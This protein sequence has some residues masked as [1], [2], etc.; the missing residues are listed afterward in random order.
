MER[1]RQSLFQMMTSGT[2]MVVWATLVA[3]P[4][5]CSSS[6]GG[7]DGVD[8]GSSS[9]GP[10][11]TDPG[12]QGANGGSG[13]QRFDSLDATDCSSNGPFH[14]QACPCG[15]GETSSCWTGPAASRG[16]GRCHD[17]TQTCMASG[18]LPTWG[19]CEGEEKNCDVVDAGVCE[20]VPGAEITCDED[21]AVNLYCVSDGRKTCLPDRTWSPCRED[22]DAAPPDIAGAISGALGILGSVFGDGGS[23]GGGPCR[24]TGFG[25]AAVGGFSL[26]GGTMSATNPANQG[27]YSG[28][29]SA[30]FA[31]GH[32]P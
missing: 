6:R 23:V 31:C 29:C 11:A 27:S 8:G 15:A 9:L 25:C 13:A 19:P 14:S 21:C 32:A 17:G 30:V 12:A 24:N 28:D 4:S 26:T 2:I 3:V 18:E 1:N 22:K 10:G 7:V 16:V 20:C 5:G